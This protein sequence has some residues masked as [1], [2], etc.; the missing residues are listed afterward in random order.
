MESAESW[1]TAVSWLVG[2][3]VLPT[4]ALR[5]LARAP[6]RS[7]GH[8]VAAWCCAWASQL[9]VPL[10]LV[11]WISVTFGRDVYRIGYFMAAIVY[12]GGGAAVA[13]TLVVAGVA[14]LRA[15]V[16]ILRTHD[17][18]RAIA[19]SERAGWQAMRGLL[20]VACLFLL[21]SVLPIPGRFG[22]LVYL[23][24]VLAPAGIAGVLIVAVTR[25]ALGVLRR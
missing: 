15:S 4:L 11:A 24:L 6:A 22:A 5:V 16:C 9:T 2:S 3:M 18:P 12:G 1:I 10:L 25:G 7:W 23:F 8:R 19:L 20:G 17:D 14:L 21:T 13:G